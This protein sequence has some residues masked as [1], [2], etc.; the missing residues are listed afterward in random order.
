MTEANQLRGKDGT[1]IADVE[2]L[3]TTDDPDLDEKNALVT[4]AL[5]HGRRTAAHVEEV[6][7]TIDSSLAVNIDGR[8][9]LHVVASLFGRQDDDTV[10]PC[11]LDDDDGIIAAGQK[12]LLVICLNYVKDGNGNWVPMTQP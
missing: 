2:T 5:I 8:R 9:G 1:K 3:T 11:K 4:A 6:A 10:K 7:L 12:T